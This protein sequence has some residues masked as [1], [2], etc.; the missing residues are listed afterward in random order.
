M[1]QETG[2]ANRNFKEIETNQNRTTIAVDMMK[3]KLREKLDSDQ[4]HVKIASAMQGKAD[5]EDFDKFKNLLTTQLD[6]YAKQLEAQVKQVNLEVLDLR[7]KEMEQRMNE[8][9]AR[10]QETFGEIDRVETTFHGSVAQTFKDVITEI[11]GMKQQQMQQQQKVSANFSSTSCCGAADTNSAAH[12]CNSFSAGAASASAAGAHDGNGSAKFPKDPKDSSKAEAGDAGSKCHCHHVQFLWDDYWQRM[13]GDGAVAATSTST[14]SATNTSGNCHCVHLTELEKRVEQVES[15]LLKIGMHDAWKRPDGD[16]G[17]DRDG[18]KPGGAGSGDGGNGGGPGGGGSGGGSGGGRPGTGDVRDALPGDEI[19]PLEN[20]E[21]LFDDKIAVSEEY[22]YNGSDNGDRWRTK[23]RGYWISKCPTLIAVLDWAEKHDEK[24]VG[25]KSWRGKTWRGR[26]L[27]D[28]QMDRLSELIWGFLNTCVKDGGRTPFESADTLNGLDA[29]RA[30]V[31]EIQKSRGIRLKQLRKT[32]QSQPAISKVEDV[33]NGVLKFENNIREYVNAGG[34]R[35]SDKEMKSDLIDAL[36]QEI[37]ENLVWRL[38]SSEPFSAFRDH[39]RASANDV[40]YH[41]GKLSRPLQNVNDEDAETTDK[42][43]NIVG[44][45]MK[46]MG[47]QHGRNAAAGRREQARPGGAGGDSARKPKCA[48]CSSEKH[49]TADCDKPK[50]PFDKRPCHLCGKPGH[51]AS[52]CRSKGRGANAVEEDENGNPYFGNLNFEDVLSMQCEDEFPPVPTCTETRR[53]RTRGPTTHAPKLC[54]TPCGC[55][56]APA[57]SWTAATTTKGR[58]TPRAVTV[59]DFIRT[60]VRNAYEALNTNH[61]VDDSDS[62][63]DEEQ[64]GTPTKDLKTGG[65]LTRRQRKRLAAKK[66]KESAMMLN[67]ED[68][69]ALDEMIMRNPQG[70]AC[71]QPNINGVEFE[72]DDDELFNIMEEVEIEVAN[73]SGSVAHVV[74]PEDVPSNVTLIRS[75]NMKNFKGAGGDG[76]KNYGKAEVECIQED[77]TCVDCDLN[78]A[79]V[80]RALHSTGVICDTKKEVLFTQGEATVVPAGTFSRYLASVQRLMEYKRKGG[81]YVAKIKVRRRKNQPEKPGS[82]SAVPFGRQSTKR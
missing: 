59:D 30:I 58:P 7:F 55:T 75:P 80:T 47:Y 40:L 12:N 62:D 27:P 9:G 61:D 72:C 42:L 63:S 70:P 73:D 19:I 77:G 45:I 20:I 28:A 38:P 3:L 41:R 46:K 82:G 29:W 69:K 64:G 14:S 17:G 57:S 81:L 67:E 54:T 34:D 76:I 2:R 10:I 52:R 78:V 25:D 4:V 16:G 53:S 32:V 36:P 33:A 66:L 65:E 56:T 11:E 5:S 8:F 71:Q 23:I 18:D 6:E 21:K 79:G 43:E 1:I 24:A 74:G 49:A 39:V 22:R 31:E 26:R 15:K 13:D 50:V 44:A 48:N 68:D 51:T 35:P 37:R 60:D